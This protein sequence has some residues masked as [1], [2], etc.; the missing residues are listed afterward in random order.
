MP[1]LPRAVAPR[2]RHRGQLVVGRVTDGG[3]SQVLGI[4][5]KS[6]E[7]ICV[8]YYIYNINNENI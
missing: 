3:G 8:L 2:R 4:F 5:G 1:G 7:T 6:W